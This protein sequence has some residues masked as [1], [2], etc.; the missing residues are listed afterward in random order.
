M[1]HEP[2]GNE[3]DYAV[4]EFDENMKDISYNIGM[5]Y[6][7]RKFHIGLYYETGREFEQD[8]IV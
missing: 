1:N 2:S 4:L 7:A 8:M 5:K 3:F 6:S